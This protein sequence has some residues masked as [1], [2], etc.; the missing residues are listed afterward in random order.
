MVSSHSSLLLP[1]GRREQS[2]FY[3]GVDLGKA[4]DP[5]AIAVV[6]RVVRT[7][8]DGVTGEAE[9]ERPRFF[10]GHLERLPLGM[11]YP[12]IVAHVGQLLARPPL[13]G[14]CEL[15]VDGTGVGAPVVDMFRAGGL[16]LTSVV[17]TAGDAESSDGQTAR[18][19]KLVLISRVEALLH[20]GR[21]VIHKDLRE[22]EALKAELLDFRADVTASGFWRFGAR[23]GKHDD[24]LLA[25]ALACWKAHAGGDGFAIM[26]YYRRESEAMRGV[27]GG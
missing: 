10:T 19:P 22:A 24:L 7:G 8:I 12:A 3:M 14:N 13:A 16:D 1:D 25:L 6:R 23:S 11:T 20:D 5:T 18:V 2:R 15:V 27:Q 21:L 4:T 17:I 26:E 9:D